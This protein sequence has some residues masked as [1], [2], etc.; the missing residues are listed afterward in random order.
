MWLGAFVALSL[1]ACGRVQMNGPLIAAPL[2]PVVPETVVAVV[3]APHEPV[4][5]VPVEVAGDRV[6]AEARRLFGDS[7]LLTMVDVDMTPPG[8]LPVLEID[9]Y[10]ENAR[11]EHYVGLFSGTARVRIQERLSRGTR[12]ESMIRSRLRQ[13]GIPEDFRYL[14]L[15]ESGFDPDAYSS[16]AAVGMWQFMPA[17]ARGVGLRVDWWVDERRD[18]VRSTD[19]AVKFLQQLQGQF[20]SL[21]LAAAAYNGGPG[22]VQRGLSRFAKEVTRVEPDD[23]F[24]TLASKNALAAETKNYV[25][26]LI[27]A[28]LIG[29]DP[30]AFGLAIDTQPA[31]VF[32][33]VVVPPATS[34]AAVGAACAVDANT[35]LEYNGQ[36]LRGMT[37]PDREAHVLWVPRGCAP[38][39]DDRLALVDDT[40]RSGVRTHEVAKGETLTGLAKEVGITT[41]VLRQY[42]PKL[43]V[44]ASGAL[45][46]GSTV[47]LPTAHT[48]AV[49]RKVPDPSSAVSGGT[50]Y[51]VRRGDTL[52]GIAKRHGT[53]V[54]RLKSLNGMRSD[55]LVAGKTIR[56]R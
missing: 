53:T 15:I 19:A 44:S 29:R 45:R 14:A 41:T 36:I 24:F 27:A 38:G 8:E 37:P 20:G 7:A 10:A 49:V 56:V 12:Y 35:I 17:T 47:L 48:L 33:S 30:Q 28:A 22:R 43:T 54:S 39:F 42:N 18:V 21:Y 55:K 31:F 4:I 50:R 34:L 46:V 5:V 23:R 11:V 1:A 6:D 2:S 9:A 25:P 51:T 26:Q 3:P 52:S 40:L 13:G 32:D 16:A